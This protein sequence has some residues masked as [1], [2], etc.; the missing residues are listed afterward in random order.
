MVKVVN[1]LAKDME[2]W[3]VNQFGPIK[4]F[5]ENL[6]IWFDWPKS[7]TQLGAKDEPNHFKQK[8]KDSKL[9]HRQE[10]FNVIIITT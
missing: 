8:R 6:K 10:K 3:K 5:A 4:F 2:S 9:K 7:A 1:C